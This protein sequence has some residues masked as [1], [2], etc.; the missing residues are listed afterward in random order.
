MKKHLISVAATLLT[1]ANIATCQ[2]EIPG[3]TPP[4]TPD[5]KTDF[6]SDANIQILST[7]IKKHNAPEKEAI[8][9]DIYAVDVT[10]TKFAVDEKALCAIGATLCSVIGCCSALGFNN[11]LIAAGFGAAGAWFTRCSYKEIQY[12]LTKSNGEKIIYAPVTSA[13]LR[14]AIENGALTLKVYDKH[15]T[16][17]TKQPKKSPEEILAIAQEIIA[18]HDANADDK[19]RYTS[20]LFKELIEDFTRSC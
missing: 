11:K 5:T 10:L 16:E 6:I 20:N 7:L 14:I 13:T 15:L 4:V 12:N 3:T 8:I 18:A 19:D 2:Q 17:L 9:Q 1:C